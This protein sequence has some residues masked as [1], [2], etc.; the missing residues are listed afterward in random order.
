MAEDVVGNK[1]YI[2]PS[3]LRRLQQELRDLKYKERP[4]VTETVA[5]AASNGDRSE[6]GDYI[7]G[8]KRLREID[9]K[10]R[11]LSKQIESAEVIDPGEVES[12]RIQF[13]ATVT[14]RAEDDHEKTY[15]IVGIDE[16]DASAGRISWKSP[17]ARALMNGKAGSW[18]TFRSP[19]GEQEIEIVKVEYLG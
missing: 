15:T 14:I 18:V 13:G 12:D 8:K 17:L 10:I 1:N 4:E 16:S 2:T 6:N 5:W 9:K 11:F 7:Y 19:K 3:G